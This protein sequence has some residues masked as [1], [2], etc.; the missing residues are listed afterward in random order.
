ME[1]VMTF[2]IDHTRFIVSQILL[3]IKRL[4]ERKI[5]HRDL[6]PESLMVNLNGYLTLMDMGTAKKL[7][8]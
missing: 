6:K 7:K 2:P 4:H 5:V 1:K 3:I 8:I